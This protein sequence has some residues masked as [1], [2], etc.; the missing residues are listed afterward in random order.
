MA[1]GGSEQE[2]AIVA[3][4]LRSYERELRRD[5]IYT[6]AIVRAIQAQVQS[7]LS[8]HVPSDQA[9]DDESVHDRAMP[10]LLLTYADVE[11]VTAMSRRTLERAVAAGH[12]VAVN[13]GGRAV[14]FR[15]DDVRRYVDQL[16]T[17]GAA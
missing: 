5:G 8:R 9:D 16:P 15:P 13:V 6:P 4:A 11:R 12:L 2:L 10:A 7:A 1:V 14:R 3:M 17:R